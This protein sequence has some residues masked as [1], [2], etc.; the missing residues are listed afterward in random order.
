MRETGHPGVCHRSVVGLASQYEM[1]HTSTRAGKN[2]P[3]PWS[4]TATDEGLSLSRPVL[5]TDNPSFCRVHVI[6]PA[7]ASRNLNLL[8]AVFMKWSTRNRK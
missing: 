5:A 8:Q 1:T 4:V 7:K 3:I 2:I 6:S